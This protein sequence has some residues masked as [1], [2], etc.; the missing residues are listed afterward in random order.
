MSLPYKDVLSQ[1]IDQLAIALDDAQV[2]QLLAYHAGLI[3]WNKAYNLTAVR[4]PMAMVQRHL[5]D[6]L[7]ILPFLPA[8]RLLDVG[9]GGGL[10]GIVVAIARPD[11]TVTLLDSN[12]KKI[13]F[14]RQMTMELGLKSVA[15]I[16]SRVESYS[17][18][19][20]DVITSRAFATLADMVAWSRHLLAPDGQ[21]IAM[22]GLYPDE[23]LAALPADIHVTSVRQ[24]QVPGADG[25][26]HLVVLGAA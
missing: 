21:F 4:D 22:K 19:P 3:K 17:A 25:Q 26:R 6:S 13:R 12:G 7:S 15:T 16:Q 8:G 1:A 24:L 9:T 11:I 18:E 2:D 20:F 23:E 14:L 10:P 5:I